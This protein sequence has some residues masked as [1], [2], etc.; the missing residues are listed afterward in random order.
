MRMKIGRAL[1][2]LL[3]ALT[4]C[5]EGVLAPVGPIG[6]GERTI[7]FN[8]LAIMMAIV[9]P[10]ILAA[11]GF[12]W[13]FR[14]GNSKARYLP[15]WAYSGRVEL[16]VWSIPLLVILFLGGVIWAGSHDLDPYRPIQSKAKPLEVQVV[17]LDWKWLFI[18]PE[19]GVATVNELVVPAGIPVHFSLTSASVMNAF[20]VPRAGSMIYTMN[21]MVTQLHL[22]VDK[23]GSY[24]GQSAQYSG[25]GF[26]DMHFQMRAVPAAEFAG[27]AARTR[28]Q[29]LTLDAGVYQGLARQGTF[30]K[31]FAYGVVQHGLFDLIAKQQIA[32]SAGPRTGPPGPAGPEVSPRTPR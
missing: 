25:D 22:Q 1:P 18:Y 29:G 5:D 9:I 31:P 3:L 7:L 28:G 10:T 17:S 13:W 16:V 2:I 30:A 14:A 20:F 32:P 24:W 19:Q 15:E 8:S 11:L 26:S 12:A 21:G 4:G 23:V 6:A 27:W